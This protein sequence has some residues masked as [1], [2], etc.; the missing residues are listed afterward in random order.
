VQGSI[1]QLNHSHSGRRSGVRRWAR[2]AAGVLAV[3]TFLA[4]AQQPPPGSPERPY[5][6][7]EANRLPDKNAQMKM[8]EQQ[9]KT[10]NFEAANTE[11]KKQIADDA[12]RLLQLA[13]ELK[14]AVDKTDKDTL[15]VNV[16]RKA[17]TIE[18]LAKGV[19]EKM[20]LTVGTS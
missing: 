7:P 8:N 20:K 11:R 17:E 16:I 6:L 12:A 3:A 1:P 13:T 5:L 2:G 18:K 4:V 10:A 15:S 19:K 9:V 14:A